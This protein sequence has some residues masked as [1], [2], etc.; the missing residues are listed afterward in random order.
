MDS[1]FALTNK[2]IFKSFKYSS[3]SNMMEMKMIILEDTKIEK[4]E[5][6]LIKFKIM[7]FL[8][9]DYETSSESEE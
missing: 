4:R 5:M 8:D 2:N 6:R 7:F 9:E 3:I 1:D